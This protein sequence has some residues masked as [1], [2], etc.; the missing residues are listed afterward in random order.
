MFPN[1]KVMA[2][3]LHAMGFDVMLWVCPYVSPDS[4]EYRELSSKGYFVKD[5]N[6][7]D[8]IVNWWNGHSACYDMT[9]P[10]VVTYLKE[11]LEN[12]QQ[13]YNIDGFKFD[14][15]DVAYMRGDYKFFKEDAHIN[16]FT[17]AWAAFALNFP[18]NEL[19]TS[20]KLGGTHLIQRLGDKEYSWDAVSSLIPQMTLAGLMGH[21][22]VCPDMIGG[23][24]FTAFLNIDS[25]QFDQ[26]LIVRSAQI[27]ALMPMM[28]FSVA[29][30]RILDKEHMD[31]VREA[32]ELHQEFA[33]YILEQALLASTT[34]EPIV[35]NLEFAFPGQGFETCSDQFMLGDKYLVAPMVTSGNSRE[36][37]LP[38]GRWKDDL[39]KR[40]RGGRTIVIDV[41]LNRIPYFEKL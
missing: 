3:S 41:P 16:D 38:K 22:Y 13:K 18:F 23:G 17:E 1:P 35:K 21:P 10:A 14:G 8:A 26:E 2:D 7:R 12:L 30:W 39:G 6:G 5:K 24:Q 25:D 40:H 11:E 33:D 34:G 4:P 32:V 29:P 15:A 31:A 28:Q 9:N 20:W 36:V 37:R 27:H 19:R